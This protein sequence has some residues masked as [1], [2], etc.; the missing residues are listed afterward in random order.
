MR[1]LKMKQEASALQT[2]SKL[3]FWS[4][5]EMQGISHSILFSQHGAIHSGR[6]ATASAFSSRSDE[7]WNVHSTSYSSGAGALPKGLASVSQQMEAS[8]LQDE[9]GQL[10][11]V[12]GDAPQHLQF[13][14]W[15]CAT[16]ATSKGK[17]KNGAGT[18]FYGFSVNRSSN[19]FLSHLNQHTDRAQKILDARKWLRTITTKGC[20]WVWAHTFNPSP[21]EQGRRVSMIS[22]P[23]WPTYWVPGSQAF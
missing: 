18:Q 10:A 15:Y 7:E 17:E 5:W 6:E 19:S 16:L 13:S 4:R 12:E 1:N 9:W 14:R 3:S 20:I 23:A 11:A 2:N 21:W 8:T 22:R